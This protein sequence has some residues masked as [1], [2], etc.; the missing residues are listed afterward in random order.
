[1]LDTKALRAKIAEEAAKGIVAD[2]VVM[3]LIEEVER[4]RQQEREERAAALAWLDEAQWHVEQ[5]I[6]RRA[7]FR[8]EE[9][10]P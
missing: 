2:P 7:Q 8:R 3:A 9:S 1:M 5:E 4:L 6:A 10:K